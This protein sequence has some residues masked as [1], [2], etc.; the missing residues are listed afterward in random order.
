LSYFLVSPQLPYITES[1]ET[2]MN[3]GFGAGRG[4]RTLVG[5]SHTSFERS[6]QFIITKKAESHTVFGGVLAMGGEGALEVRW[7]DVDDSNRPRITMEVFAMLFALLP[8][9]ARILL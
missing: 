5:S 6:P 3:T 2:L 8:N 4:N 1:P 9:Q 7:T